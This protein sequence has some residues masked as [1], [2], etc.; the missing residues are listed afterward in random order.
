MV[1][2]FLD[3]EI[4]NT[5]VKYS[6][7]SLRR[8]AYDTYIKAFR[9]ATDR[10]EENG[11]VAFVT[12]GAYID[13]Q[14]LDGFRKCLLEDYNSI[15]CFNLRG[16]QRTSGE[17]S[18]K[19]GGKIFG[20]GSRTPVAITVLVRKKDKKF[21]GFIHYYDIGDYLSRGEKLKI[22]SEFKD[23][24]N[25][26]W[27]RIVPDN[28]HDWINLKD[29][30]YSS[31]LVLGNKKNK[32]KYSIFGVDYASGLS[33]NR[34]AWIYN[35]DKNEEKANAE[36][37][38][39]N[40]NEER[41]RCNIEYNKEVLNK[42][43]GENK[44][45]KETFIKNVR[46]TNAEQYNWSSGLTNK[47]VNNVEIKTDGVLRTFLIR[48]FTKVNAYYKKDIIERCSIW[49]NLF[50]DDS[51]SNLVMCIS[52]APLKKGFS[53]LMTNCIQDL[54][55]LEN[56][57]CFP[58]YIYNKDIEEQVEQYSL[59]D[60]NTSLDKK[61]INY[62]KE[63][64]INDSVLKKFKAMYGTKITKKDIFFYIY[65]VLHHKKYRELYKDNLAKEMPRIPFLN[66]FTE[67]V[68]IGKELSE[69]HVDYENYK[70]YKDI[71][72]EILIEKEDYIVDK[73]K[74]FKE[75]K[76][77]R[78][79]R[80]IYNNCIEIRNIPLKVYE[81]QINGKSAVEWIMEK[82]SVTI[83]KESKIKN[84]PN[85]YSDNPKY[86]LNLLLS[87]IALSLRTEELIDKL[88]KYEEI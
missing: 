37:L 52:G 2:E 30:K 72:L 38:I 59:F 19:E 65:A 68:K 16:N 25:V 80:I 70:N 20:S 35:F 40:Y 74:F 11:V 1:Y 73:M 21:D 13:S 81:Y 4:A 64:A 17:L 27:Q 76:K 66:K 85:R 78:K 18:R 9:W 50:P 32:E 45:I 12:N 31:F 36:R 63:L 24:S 53:V 46:K 29:P 84:D 71:G 41:V 8:N 28:N 55:L 56:S 48:P 14:S 61:R 75:G 43:L 3:K 39:N 51:Y 67:Y 79:D 26:K 15:Y 42:G 10:I 83:D 7:A 23:I 6:K 34:D 5:Y 77:V 60:E 44:K 82:Y 62:K 57:Q 49:D 22:I 87:I 54:H 47:L 58:F 69:L 33:T 86:I 88:P